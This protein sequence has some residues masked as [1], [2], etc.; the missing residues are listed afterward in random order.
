MQK[1]YGVL[2]G[3]YATGLYLGGQCVEAA[4]KIAGDASNDGTVF[5]E[6][7]HKVSLT[8]TPRGPFTID[9]YGNA[10]GT[11]FIRK[12]ERKDGKLV[13][14]IIKTYPDVSQFWTYPEAEF[15]KNPV[16]SRDWPPAKNLE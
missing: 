9:K 10:V 5:A 14:T 11:V 4:L 7:L 1:D 3:G 15:L 2:P 16:Y 13:N 8:E 6:A 12:C